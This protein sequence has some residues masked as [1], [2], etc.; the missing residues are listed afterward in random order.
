MSSGV[1]IIEIGIPFS[2]PAADGPTIQASSHVA[3]EN[4][5]TLSKILKKLQ[6]IDVSVPLVL[7][8]Y[9]NPLLA[10][11]PEKLIAAMK[12]FKEQFVVA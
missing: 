4:G 6:T 12:A 1:D 2:D 5:V 7:M 11:G 10:Y 9:L 8:S 3:L